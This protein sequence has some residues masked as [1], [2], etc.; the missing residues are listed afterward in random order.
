MNLDRASA[1][2]LLVAF[3]L[4]ALP[5]APGAADPTRSASERLHALT[6]VYLDGLFH[7]KPHLA[8]YLGVPKYDRLVQDLSPAA[9]TRR[10][11]DLTAQQRAL[12]RVEREKLA[13]EERVDAAV[14]ADGIA[15]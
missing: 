12:A 11:R 3:A 13:P 5:A 15:L 8:S 9:L 4:A 2:T 10:E 1:R 6:R 14:M 7:A